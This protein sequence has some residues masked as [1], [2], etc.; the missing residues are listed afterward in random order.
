LVSSS[1][2]GTTPDAAAAANPQSAVDTTFFSFHPAR[3]QQGAKEIKALYDG[4]V[5]L[6]CKAFDRRP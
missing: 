5:R 6:L 3:D 2:Y 1:G 4:V